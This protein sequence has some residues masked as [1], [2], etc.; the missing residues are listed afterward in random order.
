MQPQ[1]DERLP[2]SQNHSSEAPIRSLDQQRRQAGETLKAQLDK[3]R[4]TPDTEVGWPKHPFQPIH[5]SALH[6]SGHAVLA[7]LLERKLKSVT[8]IRDA[9]GDGLLVRTKLDQ[10][11][12]GIVEEILISYAGCAA[13]EG[14]YSFPTPGNRDEEKIRELNGKLPPV[15]T[16]VTVSDAEKKVVKT[17]KIFR[18]AV[19]DLAVALVTHGTL[20]GE[21]A[22]PLIKKHLSSSVAQIAIGKLKEHISQLAARKK[23]VFLL[24][25]GKDGRDD[26]DEVINFYGYDQ[27][28]YC[29]RADSSTDSREVLKFLEDWLIEHR[30]AQEL[31]LG[32]H[33]AGSELRP[34]SEDTGSRITYRELA[35]VISDN[36]C[37]DADRLTVVLG[38][39]RSEHAVSAWENFK[40]LPIGL[41]I[42]FSGDEDVEVVRE[43]MGT[44]L[45]QGDLILPGEV[46]VTK[47]VQFLDQ[48]L[49]TLQERFPSVRIFYKHDRA[50]ELSQVS[51][52]EIEDIR[53]GLE[54]RGRS[55]R[56]GLLLE[57]LGA[58]EHSSNNCQ[59]P[60]E[61]DRGEKRIRVVAQDI[62]WHSGKKRAK[63]K[64]P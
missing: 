29:V 50:A 38:A 2:A 20:A 12:T 23:P 61:D 55:A 57:N 37:G 58:V 8:V 32:M 15:L 39:C 40:D 35:A 33:G 11:P 28:L 62:E 44:V 51:E 46:G 1:G 49:E 47:E 6:E 24:G 30:N 7:V 45:Q 16:R 4:I 17:L 22:E 41:L 5:S 14:L 64:R 53:K 26:V 10:T 34:E 31:Y 54:Q 27:G 19:E 56:G 59:T 48:D 63:R 52:G 43:V 60:I 9:D 36:Y 42:A 18:L 13:A 25:W 21:E 3:V